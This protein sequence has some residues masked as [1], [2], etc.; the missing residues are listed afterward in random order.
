MRIR[1]LASRRTA[2]RKSRRFS[3]PRAPRLTC[4]EDVSRVS[5]SSA[6]ASSATFSSS[7]PPAAATPPATLRRMPEATATLQ[8]AGA[9][10]PSSG[11]A[12]SSSSPPALP[13][14]LSSSAMSRV[15]VVELDSCEIPATSRRQAASVRPGGL[16]ASSNC[17]FSSVSNSARASEWA[18]PIES[19]SIRLPKLSSRLVRPSS[20]IE[21]DGADGGGG[22]SSGEEETVALLPSHVLRCATTAWEVSASPIGTAAS[23]ITTSSAHAAHC[24]AARRNSKRPGDTPAVA[25]ASERRRRSSAAT[26]ELASASTSPLPLPASASVVLS[27]LPSPSI[28]SNSLGAASGLL[29]AGS[30]YRGLS[31][32]L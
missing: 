4:A 28:W 2:S 25:A 5:R 7:R 23:S 11:G 9:I 12:Y 1:A 32:S 31:E 14:S 13:A 26:A 30:T 16:M 22:G 15:K 17:V 3:S 24:S 18:A 21:V 8:S 6:A 10:G 20:P 27:M 29:L 19:S